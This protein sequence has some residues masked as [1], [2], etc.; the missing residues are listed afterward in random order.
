MCHIYTSSGNQTGLTG[1]LTGCPTGERRHPFNLAIFQ[2]GAISQF[3]YFI[4][5]NLVVC[6]TVIHCDLVLRSNIGAAIAQ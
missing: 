5:S 1:R 2:K 4:S 3:C 6:L